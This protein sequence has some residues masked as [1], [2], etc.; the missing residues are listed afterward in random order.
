MPMASRVLD[1]A[2]VTTL[3]AYIAPGGGRGIEA[4]RRLGP[5]AVLD[6]VEASG[7]RGRGGAG[8]PTGRK[9][10]TI[11]DND[12]PADPPTVVVNAA[13]GEPGSFKDRAIL[14]RNPYKV[15][16]GALIAAATVGADRLVLA[17]KASFVPE[18]ERVRAAVAE[19]GAAGWAEGI[20]IVVVE[21][22]SAYLYG[23]ET[24]LLEV[25]DGR[26][27]FP[28]IAP[29]FR[30]GVEEV[31]ADTASAAGT[32]M[33]TPAEATVAAPTLVNNVETMANVAAILAEGPDWFRSLG[34]AESPGTI[35]CTVSGR[36]R[37]HGVAEFAMGTPL[38]EV[39][40]S[41]GEGPAGERLVAA[42]S[43]VANPLIPEEL[44]DTPLTYEHMAAIDS[45]LGA[46][47]F[48]VFDETVDPV[49]VAHG[50]SRFLAVESCGQ[51]TPCKQDGIGIAEVLH[52]MLTGRPEANDIE[53]VERRLTTVADGARC[54]LATQHQRVVQS[55]L[56]LFPDAV[57]AHA[58]VGAP[59]AEPELIAAIVDLDGDRFVLDDAH[60]EKQ[61]DWT[62]EDESSG[63]APA[64]RIDQRADEAADE[65][66][67][68][69]AATA[70]TAG[71]GAVDP[72]AT[73]T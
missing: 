49:A 34:T 68:T 63:Q 52:R 16:E 72:P 13:E 14:R 38:R 40:E 50:V 36:T 27:P 39:I 11:V 26:Q 37:R 44:F 28:R 21:G 31:G 47:G 42:M 66:T 4:A 20:D 7:L 15:L 59:A 60:A 24:A 23:E 22:P 25:V 30:H 29:P 58:A 1:A 51:C 71:D 64:D 35:V 3:D 18:L 41:I 2:A 10:R 67:E 65:A 69:A 9:W 12:T 54:F 57:Q 6:D 32:V 8:F 56:R 5:A 33:A 62:F 19:V 17:L 73:G 45:G 70:A 53:L 46:A 55:V 61:P 43:G 48:I